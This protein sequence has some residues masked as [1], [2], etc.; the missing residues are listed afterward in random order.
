MGMF[1][2]SITVRHL[3]ASYLS[4]REE[5]MSG[6][7]FLCSREENKGDSSLRFVPF[8]MTEK[9]FGMMQS[10]WRRFLGFASE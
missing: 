3:L 8:G 9:V 7:F 6:K 10:K 4:F 1:D 2:L 5:P